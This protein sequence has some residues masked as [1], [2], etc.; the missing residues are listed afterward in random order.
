MKR[1]VLTPAILAV[2]VVLSA[3]PIAFASHSGHHSRPFNGRVSGTA[4]AMSQ[5][6]SALTGTGHFTHLGKTTFTGATTGTGRAEQCQ[7]FTGTS[8]V[9]LTAAN[10][11]ELFLSSNDL[12]CATSSPNATP[13]TSHLTA[14]IT[15]TGGTGRFAGASGSA[16]GQA[17][18]VA[19]S[20]TATTSTFSGTI[21]GTISY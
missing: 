21:T 16:T 20:A 11:D 8:Q 4:T 2:L 13:F 6:M 14:S 9:T 15:F 1:R 17:D 18:G 12:F 7:G 3:F 19:S 10:G 5:T